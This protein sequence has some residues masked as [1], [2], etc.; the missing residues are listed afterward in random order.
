MIDRGGNKLKI[1]VFTVVPPRALLL[2]IAG[3]MEVLRSANQ[4][5]SAL[6]FSVRYI[7]PNAVVQSSAGLGLAGIHS[8][9]AELP[10]DAVVIVPGSVEVLLGGRSMIDCDDAGFEG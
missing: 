9:P 7:G 8:L 1:S 2:D 4:Q 3:P 5:Q 6:E 10:E